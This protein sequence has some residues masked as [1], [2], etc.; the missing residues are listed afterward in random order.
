MRETWHFMLGESIGLELHLNC[1]GRAQ[2]PPPP[3][4]PRNKTKNKQKINNNKND[5]IWV[6]PEAEMICVTI[7]L[8]CSGQTDM[9][10]ESGH[11]AGTA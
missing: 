5:Q 6:C 4:K 1:G 9:V 10:P 3:K 7:V 11:K 8:G 2:N